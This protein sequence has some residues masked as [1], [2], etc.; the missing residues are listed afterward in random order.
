MLSGGGGDDTLVGG[1]GEDVAKF[2][3]AMLGYDIDVVNNKVTDIDVSDGN[4][5]TDTLSGIEII[6]F[7]DGG[8]LSFSSEG[9]DEF[10]ANSWGASDQ[11]HP[12]VAGLVGGNYV[13]TWQDSSGHSGGSSWDVRGQL[14]SK[15][16][17]SIGG[18][19]RV[20]TYTS[21]RQYDPSVADRN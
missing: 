13:V 3:G 8:E 6:R 10:R 9:S 19:F 4:D 17:A 21:S 16:G 2:E 12:S 7:G 11:Y 14:Y 5:G 1:L 18:E 15:N 20:N